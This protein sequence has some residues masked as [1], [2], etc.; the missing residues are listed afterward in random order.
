MRPAS[1]PRPRDPVPKSGRE[2]PGTG[3]AEVPLS[4]QDRVP[5]GALVAEEAPDPVAGVAAAEHGGLV[6]AGGGEEGTVGGVGEVLEGG[7]GASVPGA[8]DG[9][10]AGH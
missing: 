3:G 8:H 7:E 5:D 9:D 6:V 10:L 4:V 1:D 2:V